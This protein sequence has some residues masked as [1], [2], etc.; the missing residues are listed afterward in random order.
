MT[1]DLETKLRALAKNGE[2]TYMSVCPVAGGFH[3]RVTPASRFGHSDGRD[4]D[5]V[6]A[7]LAAIDGLPK[8][9]SKDKPTRGFGGTPMPVEEEREPWEA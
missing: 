6:K 4:A 1:G 3:A 9:F 2:F 7:L 5:P 8:S